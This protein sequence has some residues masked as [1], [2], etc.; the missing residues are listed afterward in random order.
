MNKKI[1][2]DRYGIPIKIY[3]IEINNN[4]TLNKKNDNETN[5]KQ[6]VNE[7]SEKVNENQDVN[8]TNEKVIKMFTKKCGTQIKNA[9]LRLRIESNILAQKIGCVPSVMIKIEDGNY[10]YNGQLLI[11]I[12]K[13]LGTTIKNI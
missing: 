12:N 1:Y 5:E 9:R 13:Q 7:T 2:R 11:K 10:P 6:N 3:N 8:E 4:N